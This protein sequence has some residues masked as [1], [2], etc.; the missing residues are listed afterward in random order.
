MKNILS[1]FI[2]ALALNVFSG[3][4]VTKQ[5]CDHNAEK[6]VRVAS[7][8]I[9]H[10][11]LP[12]Y[13]TNTLETVISNFYTHEIKT[14]T[15]NI[16]THT[17][18]YDITYV[19]TNYYK[20]TYVITNV[21][22]GTSILLSTNNQQA[23]SGDLSIYNV[24]VTNDITRIGSYD[25]FTLL[26]DDTTGLHYEPMSSYLLSSHY[27]FRYRCVEN[28]QGTTGS[29]TSLRY[30][31]GLNLVKYNGNYYCILY[32]DAGTSIGQSQDVPIADFENHVTSLEVL[33]HRFRIALSKYLMED[34]GD[35]VARKTEVDDVVEQ[36][37]KF[38][39]NE[40]EFTRITG[41]LI[42][43]IFP[44]NNSAIYRWEYEPYNGQFTDLMF[45]RFDKDSAGEYA[46]FT[47]VPGAYRQMSEAYGYKYAW[48]AIM[49]I[50]KHYMGRDG[51][52]AIVQVVNACMTTPP[53][54]QLDFT[55]VTSSPE[56]PHPPF[57][58]L[59]RLYCDIDDV[60]LTNTSDIV[61]NIN[62]PIGSQTLPSQYKMMKQIAFGNFFIYDKLIRESL[63][64]VKIDELKQW[65][66]DTFVPKE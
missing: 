49:K 8:F 21:F 28:P 12:T 5:Y 38:K 19:G 46:L 64:N 35:S 62:I 61:A 24:T 58:V 30:K 7:N 65:A 26:I 6:G 33:S 31:A 9:E 20:N 37:K 42:L 32:D 16:H 53:D 34:T 25:T 11:T 27:Y 50:Y 15:S 51:F 54:N 45:N 55:E 60:A 56:I 36:M 43:S 52:T 63:F 57:A 59:R 66:T 41:D 2:V 17:D 44:T 48:K 47:P 22:N 18:H 1:L 10:V 3:I 14:I 23:L 40:L 13:V 39:K 29:G 4:Q